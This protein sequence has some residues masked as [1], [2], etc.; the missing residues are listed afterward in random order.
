MAEPLM[1]RR[2]KTVPI[3]TTASTSG[4]PA[5]TVEAKPATTSATASSTGSSAPTTPTPVG[6]TDVEDFVIDFGTKTKLVVG[7]SKASC[8]VFV[9]HD[10][11]PLDQL[12][13][14]YDESGKFFATR[15]RLDSCTILLEHDGEPFELPNMI[16]TPVQ[17]REK[18]YLVFRRLS[19]KTSKTIRIISLTRPTPQPTDKVRPEPERTRP[20]GTAAAA[21]AKETKGKD[22]KSKGPEVIPDAEFVDDKDVVDAEFIDDKKARSAKEPEEAPRPHTIADLFGHAVKGAATEAAGK[23]APHGPTPPEPVDPDPTTK[24]LLDFSK[25]KTFSVGGE[26]RCS[27]RV[28]DPAVDRQHLTITKTDIG[29]HL[30]HLSET[31]STRIERNGNRLP[32]IRT[33]FSEPVLLT[34]VLI[35]G[36]K[37]REKRLRLRV[38]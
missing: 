25:G 10:A 2:V 3:S 38:K 31:H 12:C 15:Q 16:P 36:Y 4:T 18:D 14:S 6:T 30:R 20:E 24:L 1:T 22:T 9:D 27:Q 35:L 28:D 19:D 7:R 17:I 8:D 23:A 11:V 5:P 21:D 29:M 26:S 34:D 33:N 37:G 13:F 32:P